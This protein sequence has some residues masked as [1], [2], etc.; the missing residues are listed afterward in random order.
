MVFTISRKLLTLVCAAA[1]LFV[2]LIGMQLV[3]LRGVIKDE[4][5]ELIRTHVESAAALAR[6]FAARAAA[7]EMTEEEAKRQATTA[8][9][10]VRYAGDEYIFAYDQTGINVAHAKANLIGTS[11][12]DTEDPNGVKVVQL[13]IDT[14]RAGGGYFEYMWPRA[15]FDV[16]IAKLSYTEYL[17]EWGW[18]IGTGVYIDDLQAQLRSATIRTVGSLAFILLLL[19]AAGLLIARSVTNPLGRLAGSIARIR[20]GDVESPVEGIDRRDEIGAMAEA[21]DTLRQGLREK[22][23][24]EA[25]QGR[26][27]A[28]AEA[29]RERRAAE[30]TEQ[31]EKEEARRCE[32]ERREAAQRQAEEE[33]R[34]EAEAERASREAEQSRVVAALASAME[35]L[36]A[37]NLGARI[38][39]IFPEAY[40]RLRLNFNR[41]VDGLADLVGSIRSASEALTANAAEITGAAGDLSRRTETSA[42]TLEETAAALNELTAAVKS[43]AES[44]RTVDAAVSDAG[45]RA[46]TSSKVMERSMATMSAIERSSEE[47]NKIT[48]VIDDIAFQTNLLALNAGVEAARAGD[49]GRGFAVVASEVRALAQRSSD[50][51]REIKELI[52]SSSAQVQSGVS[53]VGQADQELREILRAVENIQRLVGDIAASAGEQATGISEINDAV[54]QLDQTTQSNVAMFE[55]TTAA[56]TALDSEA[57][58][59]GELVDRFQVPTDRRVTQDLDL[60]E[61]RAA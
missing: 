40:D 15:D 8:L 47:I 28:E 17:P 60:R 39:G 37:G 59:L 36:A 6:D 53:S 55:E 35:G 42:A 1:V 30:K 32:E 18:S 54:V 19:V 2:A 46:R 49:A 10:A 23:A 29:D 31:T 50:A 27:R 5:T 12:W 48:S 41:A 56:T 33:R 61:P 44:A 4:K 20:E 3:Q 16:P 24:L 38:D 58:R 51:A 14:A 11:L 9:S 43:A 13:M 45:D 7:G 34:A 21:V 57:R 26:L 22:I 52:G 25:E